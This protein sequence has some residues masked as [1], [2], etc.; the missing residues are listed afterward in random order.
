MRTTLA[1][2]VLLSALPA[3]AQGMEKHW[4]ADVHWYRPSLDGHY[5]DLSGSSPISV[6]LKDDLALGRQGSHPGFGLEYQGPRFG[7]ELSRDQQDYSG[8]NRVSRDITIDGQ[9]FSASTVVTSSLKA[10][11]TTFNWTIRCFTLP[12]FWIGLDLGGQALETEI[13]ASGE[14]PLSATTTTADYKTT[15]PVPQIGPSL[16]FVA[17]GGRLVGRGMYH[18]LAYKGCTYNNFGADLRYFPISWLGMR[19]FAESERFRVPKDSLK[20]N[21]DARLDR[22]GVGLG[23]VARF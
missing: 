1:T 17:A 16:G 13:R 2:L 7:V 20:N 15:F 6:D 21:L 19:V 14:D 10:T 3:L 12:E 22:S 4:Y 9:T 18:F 23:I 5:D 11:T 8:R